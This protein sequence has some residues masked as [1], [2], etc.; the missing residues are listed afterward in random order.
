MYLAF[1]LLQLNIV[2]WEQIMRK[3]NPGIRWQLIGTKNKSIIISA[4]LLE[5]GAL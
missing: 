2:C 5:N 3:A 1:A 4:S